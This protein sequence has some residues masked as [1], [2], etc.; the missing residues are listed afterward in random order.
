MNKKIFFVLFFLLPFFSIHTQVKDTTAKWILKKISNKTKQYTSVKIEFTYKLENGKS[1]ISEQKDGDI[2]IQGN[3]YRLNIPGQLIINDGTTVWTYLKDAEE[4]TIKNYKETKESITP[5]KI[6][7]D[8]NKDFKPKLIR[9]YTENGKKYMII[10]LTPSTP[11]S[12]YK[13]RIVVD[14]SMQ[15]V[16]SSEFFEKEGNRFSY[17]IRKLTPN[18]KIDDK[19]FSFN[20]K[21]YPGVEINDVR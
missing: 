19:M 18:V 9:E 3:K 8:Y 21:D 4:V 2:V 17:E 1:K 10:D 20:P 5:Q 11:R 12:F 6:L 15:Q 13:L 7:S 16:K 14:K